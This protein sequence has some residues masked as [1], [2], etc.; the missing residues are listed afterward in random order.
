MFGL[1]DSPVAELLVRVRGAFQDG[2][3]MIDFDER[4]LLRWAV[5][6]GFAAVELDYRAQLDVPAEPITDWATLRNT[7]PNPLAPTYGEAM[8]ATLT[9][10][11]QQRLDEYMTARAEAATPTRRTMATVFLR[12]QLPD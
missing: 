6:A 12:A 8:A 9:A 5:D 10:A 3:P 11:E 1:G 2:Q 4:D 7:A